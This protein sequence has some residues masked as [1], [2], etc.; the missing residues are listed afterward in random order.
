MKTKQDNKVIDHISAVNPV[1]EIELLWMIGL[2][3]ISEE[4]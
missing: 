2:G 1:N 3:I 4:N